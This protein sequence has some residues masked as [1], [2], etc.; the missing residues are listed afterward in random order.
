MYVGVK[1]Q[2]SSAGGC[3]LALSWKCI[4]EEI[5]KVKQRLLACVFVCVR[6][7]VFVYRGGV[8]SLFYSEHTL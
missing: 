5:K 2:V 7:C 8:M 1:A 6:V 4:T 3:I